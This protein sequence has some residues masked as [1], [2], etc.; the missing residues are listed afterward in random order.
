MS[1]ETPENRTSAE[2]PQNESTPIV[3]ANERTTGADRKVSLRNKLIAG[4]AGVALVAG[5][6]AVGVNAAAN[7]APSSEPIPTEP[8]E[9][10]KGGGVVDGEAEVAPANNLTPEQMNEIISNCPQ[11]FLNQEYIDLLPIVSQAEADAIYNISKRKDE[12]AKL[13]IIEILSQYQ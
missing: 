10:N 9:P 8:S 7:Q 1:I 4:A 11:V 2:N 12:G 5:G 3:E 13:L 6:V